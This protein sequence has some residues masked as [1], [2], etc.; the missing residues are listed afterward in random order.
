[1]AFTKNA[2]N[3]AL[4]TFPPFSPDNPGGPDWPCEPWSETRQMSMSMSYLYHL[5]SCGSRN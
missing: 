5:G 4:H 1:M 2:L 3:T